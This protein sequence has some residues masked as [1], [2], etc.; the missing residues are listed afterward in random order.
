MV[1]YSKIDINSA[2]SNLINSP[3]IYT[4]ELT[5]NYLN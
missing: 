2:Y 4:E 1:C 5:N 3:E